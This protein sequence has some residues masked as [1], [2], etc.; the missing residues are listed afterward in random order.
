MLL[1]RASGILLHPTSFPNGVLDEHAFK[2]VDWLASAG[3]SWWQVLPLGPPE[4]LTGSPYMSPSAFAGSPG[5]LA[6]PEA[7]VSGDEADAF[8]ARN[9]YWLDDWLTYGG[10]VEDQV[11]F[12]REWQALRAYAAQRGVRMFGDMPIYVAHDGADHRAHPRLF[13]QG[14]V[15]GVPPDLFAKTG[16]L[17]GNPLYDWTAMRADGYRWWI[18]RFRRTFELVDLTRVDHFRGFVSYW[19]VPE[20]EPT[21]EH[22]R[23]RRGPGA[24]VFRAVESELGEL[25]VVAEDLGVITE[26]VVRLRH[27]LGFP[28]MVV[29]HFALGRDPSNPH[30]PENHEEQSVVY[31]GTHDNDTT[32]GW[33]ESLSEADRRWSAL[34]PADPAWSLIEVAWGSRGALAVAPLQDVLGLGSEARM[35]LPGTEQGN[36][37]WRYTPEQL[38]AELAGRLQTL[39]ESVGRRAS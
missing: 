5:I 35:N 6:D 39:T 26:P 31:T 15:A 16:Q 1:E 4:G 29:L 17:W 25:A 3:Q 36:W 23:W 34:D 7:P 30:L 18:E 37:H 33:W 20:G 9:A 24:D 2:F 19:A 32:R 21:A 13:Q 10:T 22:G 28:G 14:A 8:R 12:E 38:T 27:E 11:R